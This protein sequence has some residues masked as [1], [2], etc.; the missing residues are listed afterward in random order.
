MARCRRPVLVSS[1]K[2]WRVLAAV[3]GGDRLRVFRADMGEVGSF[4]A[5][6][7]GCV[8]LFH[9]AASME[10]HVSPGQDNVGEQS[11]TIADDSLRSAHSVPLVNLPLPLPWKNCMWF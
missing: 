10:F 3:E 7:T 2:A 5:A 8:A 9:V 1:G 6:A 11:C 4:D